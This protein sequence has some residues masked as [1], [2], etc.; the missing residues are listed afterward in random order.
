M[1]KAYTKTK[2]LLNEFFKTNFNVLRDDGEVNYFWDNSESW[3][4]KTMNDLF[5]YFNFNLTKVAII[6]VFLNVRT[7][8]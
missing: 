2:P 1:L 4:W 3:N 6:L 5:V 7:W 8:K